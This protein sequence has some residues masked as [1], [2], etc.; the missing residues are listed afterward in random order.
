MVVAGDE[1]HATQPAGHEAVEEAAPMDLRLG[2]GDR[3]PEHVA[4]AVLVDADRRQ[5]GGISDHAVEANLF[6]ARVEEQV[7]EGA[8]LAGAPGLQ[9]LVHEG[10]GAADLG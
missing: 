8:E 6:V 9:L 3:D 7:G 4:L 2:E 1:V 10:R 5:D